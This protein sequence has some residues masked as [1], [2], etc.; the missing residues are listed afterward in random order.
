MCWQ[1]SLT[2]LRGYP[3]A[4]G[5]GDCQTQTLLRSRWSM[6]ELSMGLIPPLYFNMPHYGHHISPHDH[7]WVS[8]IEYARAMS[9]TTSIIL[10]STIVGLCVLW[11]VWHRGSGMRSGNLPLPPGPTPMP[12][13][14]NLLDIP[15]SH[16]WLKV[17]E[18]SKIYGRFS[19]E[20]LIY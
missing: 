2:R 5:S 13:I 17:K 9:S 6:S 11:R 10:I 3:N 18:W 8:H 20:M 4:S 14:G 16:A 1:D 12:I 15:T 7:L 19:S